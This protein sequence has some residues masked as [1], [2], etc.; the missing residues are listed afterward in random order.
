MRGMGFL[1]GAA[2][3]TGVARKKRR[4]K[5]KKNKKMGMVIT[6]KPNIK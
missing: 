1:S 4:N 3:R 6:S 5:Y 2:A